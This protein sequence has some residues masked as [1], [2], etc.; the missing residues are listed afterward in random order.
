[1]RNNKKSRVVLLKMFKWSFCAAVCFVVV[2]A[3]SWP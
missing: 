2:S 1:L 3:K